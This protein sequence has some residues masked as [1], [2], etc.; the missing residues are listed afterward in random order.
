MPIDSLSP[1]RFFAIWLLLGAQS[2]G[3]GSASLA[4]IRRAAVDAHGWLTEAEF[5]RDWAL[6]Q[7]APGI[8]LLALII[9]IG[10]RWGGARG[11]ALA[12]GGLLVPSAIATVLMTV[13]Y[14]RFATLPLVQ[15]ALRG[16]LPA[17]VGLGLLTAFQIAR[18]LLRQSRVESKL[19]LGVAV[20]LICA[21]AALAAVWARLP[22]LFILCGAGAVFALFRGV[23]ARAT[24]ENH[25]VADSS[26]TPK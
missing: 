15:A 17:T 26:T 7:L 3:G 22:V 9:L 10:R 13:V 23:T 24:P 18:P 5:A 2:F 25:P 20:A 19:S 12:L 8:N 11:I 4:L 21:C 14:A 1:R 6:V 16:I